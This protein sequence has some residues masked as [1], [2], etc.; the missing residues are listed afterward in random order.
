[1][2]TF[3]L[4]CS[5]HSSTHSPI[6]IPWW[7]N[8]NIY[9]FWYKDVLSYRSMGN[10]CCLNNLIWQLFLLHLQSA[11]TKKWISFPLVQA[12][13]FTDRT[14]GMY[15]PSSCRKGECWS[16]C[17]E[18]NTP[19]L[20]LTS[21]GQGQEIFFKKL[22][23]FSFHFFAEAFHFFKSLTNIGRENTLGKVLFNYTKK[24]I[25]PVLFPSPYHVH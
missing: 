14:T 24:K 22:L 4:D 16:C 3:L 18:F 23:Q 6:C 2:T 8:C 5:G 15:C 17:K 20:V 13:K 1:M 21:L 9:D 19:L 10:L 25:R 11:A 12:R 7:Q